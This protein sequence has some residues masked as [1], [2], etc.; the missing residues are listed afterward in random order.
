MML[1]CLTRSSLLFCLATSLVINA[2]NAAAIVEPE[3]VTLPV[4]SV[5]VLSCPQKTIALA[6]ANKALNFKFEFP[7]RDMEAGGRKAKAIEGL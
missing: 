2:S 1:W 4:A 7:S 6:F 5:V 3:D